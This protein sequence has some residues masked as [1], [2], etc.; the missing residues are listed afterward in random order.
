MDSIIINQKERISAIIEAGYPQI[1][2]FMLDLV[3]EL[4]MAHDCGE[5]YNELKQQCMDKIGD[6]SMIDLGRGHY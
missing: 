3:L 5:Y 4:W 6:G 2:L 1:A